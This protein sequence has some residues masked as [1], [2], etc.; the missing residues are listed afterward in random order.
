MFERFCKPLRNVATETFAESSA[1]W[2][3]SSNRILSGR[4]LGYFTNVKLVIHY[5]MY[6]FQP[7]SSTC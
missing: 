1:N 6:G 3:V 2:E 4:P 7:V 5:L